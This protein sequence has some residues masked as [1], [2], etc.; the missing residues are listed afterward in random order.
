MNQ[1]HAAGSARE[2]A[3]KVA[4]RAAR[5][6]S[7]TGEWLYRS[8]SAGVVLAVFLLWWLVSARQWV[9]P[10]FL[11]SPA[12]VWA[13]FTDIVREGY[14]GESLLSHIGT[15][16]RRLF[17]AL[18]LA[19][20]TAVPL[21]ILCGRFRWLRAVF[22]P[23]VEFYRP[24]PPLAYY[25]LLILW[26][27]ITDVS[28]VL[29]LFLGAF[30]PLF[31]T[32][33]FSVQRLSADRINGAKSLGAK[34]WKLYVFVIFPSILPE[35][36]TGLRT[37]VGVSYATLVAA[38]MVAAVSGVGWMVLDASKFLRSDIMYLGI[39]VM[40]LIA[41]AIDLIIR[42]LIRRVSPWIEH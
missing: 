10:L 35:L 25:T 41:V 14:K 21:G 36:L 19:F 9:N 3:G 24:L 17:L 32:A 11:P 29:L 13:A 31:I 7:G 15:S 12:A 30:A 18:G 16:M 6:R 40:A 37:A 39:I 2:S 42:M 4:V 33:V 23:F 38:E 8:I 27:G 22:D 34:G 5:R 28:K 1:D 26:F 20:V